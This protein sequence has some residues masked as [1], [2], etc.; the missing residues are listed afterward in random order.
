MKRETSHEGLE[1]SDG[2]HRFLIRGGRRI[3]LDTPPEAHRQELLIEADRLARSQ[4]IR[5]AG[6]AQL[7]AMHRQEAP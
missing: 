5:A 7:Q 4:A 6:A 3:W 2:Q 1:V